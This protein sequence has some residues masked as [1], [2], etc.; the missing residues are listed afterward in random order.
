MTGDH[1]SQLSKHFKFPKSIGGTF[2]DSLLD[3]ETHLFQVMKQTG[4]V[5]VQNSSFLDQRRNKNDPHRLNLDINTKLTGGQ[6]KAIK[7]L[8]AGGHTVV[9]TSERQQHQDGARN[10]IRD[11]GVNFSGTVHSK[12]S[13]FKL[14]EQH[15]EVMIQTAKMFSADSIVDKFITYR[16]QNKELIGSGVFDP[17]EGRIL[18]ARIPLDAIRLQRFFEAGANKIGFNSITDTRQGKNEDTDLIRSQLKEIEQ[19][20]GVAALGFDEGS[21]QALDIMVGTTD[22]EIME[23]LKEHQRSTGILDGDFTFR[24]VDNERFKKN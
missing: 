24:I 13:K 18:D 19:S 5:R 8:E 14:P 11:N 2:Y 16:N 1:Y 3:K 12:L 9:G 21:I 4:L 7:D 22:G 23:K 17:V 20:G 6:I 10:I 15:K